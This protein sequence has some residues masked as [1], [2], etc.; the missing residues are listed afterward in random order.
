ML[1]G[2]VEIMD[3]VFVLPCDYNSYLLDLF[4]ASPMEIKEIFCKVCY[5]ML[6]GP[7]SVFMPVS[8]CVI[9]YE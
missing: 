8:S 5:I 7:V 1:C 9:I 2:S 3:L 6:T 4:S